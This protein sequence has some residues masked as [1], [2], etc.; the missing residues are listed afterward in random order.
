VSLPLL[1]ILSKIF[2]RHPIKGH[3]QL[4]MNLNHDGKTHP[5]EILIYPWEQKEKSQGARLDEKE[6]GNNYHFAFGRKGGVLLTSQRFK[7]NRWRPLTTLPLKILGSVSSSRSGAGITASRHRG[8]T[9]K[10][11]IASNLYNYFE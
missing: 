3:Q 9:L 5:F 2:N 4:S 10:E 7:E 1:E 6:V 11:T 8:N